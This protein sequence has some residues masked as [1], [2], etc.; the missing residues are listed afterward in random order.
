MEI[1]VIT[2]TFRRSNNL[3]EINNAFLVKNGNVFFKFF[4]SVEKTTNSD[5][6]SQAK[7]GQ[8][9]APKGKEFMAI[10]TKFH[11]FSSCSYRL[12]LEESVS[13]VTPLVSIRGVNKVMDGLA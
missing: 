4:C 8:D 2:N 6:F 3:I 10:W 5:K 11:L 12:K 7:L 9:D 1:A 13:T